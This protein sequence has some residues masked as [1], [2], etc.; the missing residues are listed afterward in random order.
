MEKTVIKMLAT[1]AICGFMIWFGGSLLRSTIAYDLFEPAKEFQLKNT[2]NDELKMHSV[3]LF[4]TL[5]LYTNVSYGITFIAV[6]IMT[7]ALRKQLR[8]QGWL[9]MAVVLFFLAS[10]MELYKIF[11]DL[12]LSIAI[13]YD[14]VREFYNPVINEYFI[15]RFKNIAFNTLSSL[16]FLAN[17]TIIIFLIWKPLDKSNS[18]S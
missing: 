18:P 2:Y 11:L 16:S 6:F 5:S 8:S 9:F 10:P 7:I 17:F 1:F 15:M 12:K 13:Y 3:Y 4:S 14:N